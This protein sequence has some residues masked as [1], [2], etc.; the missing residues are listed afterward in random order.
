[1][2]EVVLEFIPSDLNRMLVLDVGCA[3]GYL[4]YQIRTK[5]SGNPTVLGLDLWVPYI[6]EVRSFHADYVRIY[7]DL[8]MADARYMP[9]RGQVF[10][11]LIASELLEH[12]PR[13]DG[14][15]LLKEME[16]ISKDRIITSTPSR[17]FEQEQ[18][19]NNPYQRHVSR[20]KEED[21]VKS[22]YEVKVVYGKSLNLGE[23]IGLITR[24]SK[25]LGVILA[26]K[27]MQGV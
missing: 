21:F 25:P 20:W 24:L 23:K 2:S 26:R 6:K 9:F 3:K 4:G 18:L 27:T 13:E 1:M 12:L 19:D 17:F 10:N 5:K 15:R 16:R 14:F 22:G 8:I 7:D 11:L